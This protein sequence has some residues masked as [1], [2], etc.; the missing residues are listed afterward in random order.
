MNDFDALLDEAAAVSLDGWDFSWFAGRATEQRPSWGYADLVAERLTTA[1][2]ALDVQTGGGEVFAYAIDKARAPGLL[3]ATEAWMPQV[4]RTRVP[5]VVATAGLPFSDGAFDLVV[6]RHPVNT[7][8]AGTARVVRETGIFL[9]Q[10]IGA[11]SNRELSEAMMGPL[12]P[13]DRQHPEQIRAAAEAAGFEVVQLKAERLRAE[14]YDIGAVAHFLRKVVWTVP[15]F[16]IE[17]YRDRL[18][19]VHEEITVKGMFVSHATRVLI[20]ARKWA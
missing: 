4:A 15:G 8:W 7:D 1:G 17:K 16:T 9:S 11:G 18:R 3:V 13:P 19:A 20:E 2:R 14:F 10:Q 5:T 12:P 6:S